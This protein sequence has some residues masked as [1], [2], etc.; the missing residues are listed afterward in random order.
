MA[1]KPGDARSETI[2]KDIFRSDHISVHHNLDH[3]A[4]WISPSESLP[5]RARQSDT[6]SHKHPRSLDGRDTKTHKG[7]PQ[8]DHKLSGIVEFRLVDLDGRPLAREVDM[9]MLVEGYDRP[10][11]IEPREIDSSWTYH[12]D[13]TFSPKTKDRVFIGPVARWLSPPA[14]HGVVGVAADSAERWTAARR[15]EGGRDE[16]PAFPDGWRPDIAVGPYRV[17]ATCL[18]RQGYSGVLLRLYAYYGPICR[19]FAAKIIRNKAV[20][21]PR[22]RKGHQRL[23]EAQETGTMD[24][25]AEEVEGVTDSKDEKEGKTTEM[26]ASEKAVWK[27]LQL[28]VHPNVCVLHDVMRDWRYQLV[29]ILPW[30]DLGS[31][32][33][34]VTSLDRVRG[35]LAPRI[36]ACV[37]AAT[38]LCHLHRHGIVHGDIRLDSLLVFPADAKAPPPTQ[39][40]LPPHTH[41]QDPYQYKPNP[42]STTANTANNASLPSSQLAD[43]KRRGEAHNSQPPGDYMYNP[44]TGGYVYPSGYH[45][46]SVSFNSA[47]HGLEGGVRREEGVGKKRS[48]QSLPTIPTTNQSSVASASRTEQPPHSHVYPNYPYPHAY[49]YPKAYTGYDNS[50]HYQYYGHPNTANS[51]YVQ[52]GFGPP[53]PG[54]P[55]TAAGHSAIGL[56]VVVRLAVR[57]PTGALGTIRRRV[58]CGRRFWRAPEV[59][60]AGGGLQAQPG[61]DVWSL[62]LCILWALAETGRESMYRAMISSRGSART[63]IIEASLPSPL[64]DALGKT[65]SMCLGK[66][67]SERPTA[68]DLLITLQLAYR[69]VTG[70]M[71]K[72]VKGDRLSSRYGPLGEVLGGPEHRM[73]WFHE[74]VLGK[75]KIAATYYAKAAETATREACSFGVMATIDLARALLTCG[76]GKYVLRACSLYAMAIRNYCASSKNDVAYSECAFFALACE[77]A[78]S[79]SVNQVAWWLAQIREREKKLMASNTEKFETSALSYE[80]LETNP[81]PVQNPYAGLQALYH[82]NPKEGTSVLAA[83]LRAAAEKGRSEVISALIKAASPNEDKQGI[84]KPYPLEPLLNHQAVDGSTALALAAKSRNL[85][86]AR[87]LIAGGADPTLPNSNKV[88]PL[89]R[90]AEGGSIGIV[91]LL[92]EHKADLSVA[93]KNGYTP[94]ITAA[95]NGHANICRLLLDLKADPALPK[96]DGGT[97][98]M[99]AAFQGYIEVSKLLLDSRADPSAVA[100]GG[101]SASDVT[102][103]PYVLEMLE[104]L[105]GPENLKRLTEFR[106]AKLNEWTNRHHVARKGKRLKP[107]QKHKTFSELANWMD[108]QCIKARC[109]MEVESLRIASHRIASNR[110]ASLF[111]SSSLSLSPC[112]SRYP[113]FSTEI[114]AFFRCSYLSCSCSL[115]AFPF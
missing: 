51:M 36:D 47:G 84:G 13:E 72:I 24:G 16:L 6:K 75:L 29:Y 4:L 43:R 98:L 87:K 109:K 76:G 25:G 18:P 2:Q 20:E 69:A 105:D 101:F 114:F 1:A 79:S 8:E 78:S 102:R 30:A 71:P 103:S 61:S 110:I 53:A 41:P 115:L 10:S 83:G 28:H 22:H 27:Y 107:S 12:L 81:P 37:Q 96:G 100:L 3:K 64:R 26:N 95:Q 52:Q 94:L 57:A 38:G 48:P 73:G 35:T 42:H 45:P 39:A 85:K 111:L 5:P 9:A 56:R 97:A 32:R 106:R 15:A 65:L 21:D 91:R 89:L 14:A 19:H 58:P 63:R 113:S 99:V 67:P 68:H 74:V 104:E 54:D 17:H 11:L 34:W 59:R 80:E 93:E 90:A 86:S 7:R 46:N 88:T 108:R 77:H 82:Q 31:M 66:N 60:K 49:T 92:L 50:S 112:L 44:L 33:D 23:T 55:N 40:Y 70:R 62:A